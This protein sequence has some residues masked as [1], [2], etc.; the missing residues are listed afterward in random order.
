[1]NNIITYSVGGSVDTRSARASVAERCFPS[2]KRWQNY[3]TT[4]GADNSFPLQLQM[5][6]TK[7]HK[8]IVEG[9]HAKPNDQLLII[10]QCCYHAFNTDCEPLLKN[11]FAIKTHIMGGQKKDFNITYE[12][13]KKYNRAVF[14]PSFSCPIYSF[15]KWS[16]L[17]AKYPPNIAKLHG[18]AVGAFFTSRNSTNDGAFYRQFVLNGQPNTILKFEKKV[19]E[20]LKQNNNFPNNKSNILDEIID[21]AKD[22]TINWVYSGEGKEGGKENHWVFFYKKWNSYINAITHPKLMSPLS[23]IILEALEF[24]GSKGSREYDGYTTSSMLYLAANKELPGLI[25]HYNQ[26]SRLLNNGIVP[27][28]W[29]TG[30]ENI[31][32]KGDLHVVHDIGMD[33]YVDDYI[34]LKILRETQK[35]LIIKK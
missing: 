15:F 29:K 31:L 34:A 21:H 4:G 9:I 6:A 14:T 35:S 11:T 24:V 18:V 8:N 22:T 7:K 26:L 1:M 30:L 13:A 2:N 12:I 33:P 17:I 5:V 32:R 27:V 16:K 28:E 20:L 10:G 23:A 3:T 25:K 19:A